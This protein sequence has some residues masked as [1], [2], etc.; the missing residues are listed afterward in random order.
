MASTPEKSNRRA[1]ANLQDVCESMSEG[2]LRAVISSMVIPVSHRLWSALSRVLRSQI[3]E[4]A[5]RRR[6]YGTERENPQVDLSTEDDMD[7]ESVSP[8]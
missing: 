4:N 1:W 2:D 3:A 5:M 8:E 7:E 6:I